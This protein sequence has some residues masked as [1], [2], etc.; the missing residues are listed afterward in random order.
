MEVGKWAEIRRLFEVEKLSRREISRRLHCGRTTVNAAL[1]LESPAFGEKTARASI[2]DPYKAVIDGIIAKHPNLSAV[3]VR[4]EIAKSGYI[5][6]VSLVRRYIRKIRPDRRRV[7]TEVHYEPGDAMQVDWGEAGKLQIGSTV[8]KVYVFVAVLCFS[9]LIYIEFSL[10]QKMYEF[11]SCL[12]NAL[13][14]FGGSTRRLILDNMRTAVLRGSGREAVFH[15]DFLAF[16]GHYCIMPVACMRGDPE[17][18]GITE[19]GVRYVNVNCL[20][21]RAEELV[22]FGAYGRLAPYWRNSVANVRVHASTRERPVDRFEKER[23]RLRGLPAMRFDTDDVEH[24]VVTSHARVPYDGNRYSV[25]PEYARK[26]VV[27]RANRGRVVVLHEGKEISSHI[28]C[29]E[30]GQIICLDDHRLAAINM[31]RRERR[32]GIEEEFFGLGP[33]ARKF[34]LKLLSNPV[35]PSVHLRKILA[36]ARLYGRTEVL[37]AIEKAVLLE[38]CDSAYVEN[39]LLAERRRRRLPSPTPVMP[40]RKEL[41]EEIDVEEPDP[42]IYD[43]LFGTEEEF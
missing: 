4:E 36:L 5:G 32:T 19:D 33:E 20:A 24:R 42:G 23:G 7:Y 40:K 25:P 21:G 12:V 43:R 37:A 29:L 13:E 11:L 17:S 30:K 8:R 35:K 22:D 27:V 16:C 6:E 1:G 38:T 2:L 14:F 26:P 18:K 15:P 39:I 10:S 34:H 28:R 41:I 31:R 9:R 3:R